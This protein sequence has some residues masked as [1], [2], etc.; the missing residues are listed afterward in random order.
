MRRTILLFI[1]LSIF[2]KANSQDNKAMDAMMT[3]RA[4]TCED[5]SYNCSFLLPRFYNADK[6]DSLE[7]LINYWQSKCG[8]VQ[9]L[10][11]FEILYAIKTGAFSEGNYRD[12]I[13][14][15]L[16][17]YKESYDNKDTFKAPNYKSEPTAEN[18]YPFLASMAASLQSIP[19]LSP[20][21][22]FLVNFYANRDLNSFEQLNG[23]AYKGTTLQKSYSKI[24]KHKWNA[25]NTALLAGAWIPI[26]NLNRLGAHPF[27][28]GRIGKRWDKVTVDFDAQFRF[29]NSPN[30]YQ[31][32]I[33]GHLRNTSYFFSS[34]ISAYGSYK[35]L[36]QR[37]NEIEVIG[38]IG[39]DRIDVLRQRSYYK[40]SQVEK[41][42][43]TVN[44]NV[45]ATYKY[46]Y[47][48]YSYLGVE[49]KYNFVHYDNAEGTNLMGNTITIGFV[50][51]GYNK[52][53]L[54]K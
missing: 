46:Y 34:C 30:T 27:I 7:N 25:I 10:F 6:T 17:A 53:F 2:S 37:K 19:D 15:Y 4:L 36:G 47:S 42:L 31:T 44:L 40:Y 11:S 14:D 29:F 24:K 12:D 38:G 54:S 21:E 32:Y 45:G 3:K 52:P 35:V 16:L 22:K 49:A 18:Y 33:K 26:G 41:Y 13:I 1:L 20:V 8:R 51:G 28:E 9:P 43:G 39:Y 48:H 5:V 50:W 23:S